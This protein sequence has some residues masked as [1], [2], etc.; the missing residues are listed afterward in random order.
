MFEI[1]WNLQKAL[2]PGIPVNFWVTEQNIRPKRRPVYLN[3]SHFYMY[4]YVYSGETIKYHVY[5]NPFLD[6]LSHFVLAKDTTTPTQY[7]T[8]TYLDSNRQQSFAC[9]QEQYFQS[10]ENSVSVDKGF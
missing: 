5:I 10:I 1:K 6:F 4:I 8:C 7:N 3:R 9:V 2:V